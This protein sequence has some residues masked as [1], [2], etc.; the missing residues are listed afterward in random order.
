MG[1]HQLVIEADRWPHILTQA[2]NLLGHKGFYSTCCQI[3][4]HFWW[5]GLNKDV[6]WFVKTCHQCQLRSMKHVLIP[7]VFSAPAPLFAKVFID[8]MLMPVAQG[9]R[10]LCQGRCSLS[11]YVEWAMWRTETGQSVGKFI[12]GQILCR[13]GAVSEIVTDN[14]SPVV[15][16]L[17][18]LAKKYGITHIHISPYNK[19]AKGI[20]ERNHLTV[21]E[22]LVK[23][24]GDDIK[25][26]LDLAPHIFWADRV[27]IRKATGLLPFFITHGVEPVLPFNLAEAT[28]LVP[29]LEELLSDVEL[30]AT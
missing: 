12:F 16:G 8:S 30:L 1:Q 29:K 28:F 3:A 10:Y 27:T 5:P 19:R 26:W 21:R 15:A 7:P 18:W 25:K 6:A 9:Y 24:C 22:S 14:G 23:A 20:V 13:W 2:H 4:D 11:A 17:D